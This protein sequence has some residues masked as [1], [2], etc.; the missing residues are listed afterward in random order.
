MLQR[1]MR[2]SPVY[3]SWYSLY[4]SRASAY[5]G[6]TADAVKWGIDGL[7][8]AASPHI[9]AVQ[10]ANLAFVY[11]EAGKTENAKDAARKALES[12][13]E[14]RLSNYSKLQPFEQDEDWKRMIG[15]M[16]AAGLPD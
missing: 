2:L 11:W 5:K 14:F 1:A 13:P 6:E 16:R 4:L 15:A 9:R 12:N 7:R 3:P 10:Y 8:R